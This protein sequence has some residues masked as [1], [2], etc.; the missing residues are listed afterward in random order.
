MSLL[1]NVLRLTRI[2]HSIMLV[3]AVLAA[4]LVAG[5]GHL[6]NAYVLTLSLITPIFISMAAFAIN[7]YFDIEVDRLN[8]K[9]RPLTEGSMSPNTA[10]A[11]TIFSLIVG[12]AA[13]YL[14]NIYCLW[15]AVIFGIVSV[16]YSY[17]LKETPLIGNACVAFSMAIPFIFGSFVVT[18]ALGAGLW[19]IFVMIFLSGMG[20]EIQ[21]TVRDY[22]GDV[23]IRRASTLP[24]Y[25]G[26]YL[27][28]IVAFALYVVAIAISVYLFLY[29]GPFSGNYLFGVLILLTDIMLVYSG[30]GYVVKR[31]QKFYDKSRNITLAAMALALIAILLASF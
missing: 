21:G 14:I 12:I 24:R 7:D 2:E 22:R 11:I 9:K 18:H 25:I 28:S 8:K 13:S 27:S 5:G 26:I 23:E 31:N 6:P 30:L 16:L 19:L 3:I 17:K 15:I 29:I 10:I 20:R 1:V 4:E